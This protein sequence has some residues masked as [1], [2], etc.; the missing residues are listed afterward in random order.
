MVEGSRGGRA[1][2]ADA[3]AAAA[4][5][6]RSCRALAVMLRHGMRGW[7]RERKG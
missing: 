2:L 5:V 3:A 7:V 1:A 4:A 6:D